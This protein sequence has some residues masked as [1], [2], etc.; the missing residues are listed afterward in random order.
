ANLRIAARNQ[1]IHPATVAGNRRTRS[2][3]GCRSAFRGRAPHYGRR[4]DFCFSRRR[5]WARMDRR[6]AGAGERS[7]RGGTAGQAAP[8]LRAPGLAA[9]R[10]GE[11]VSRR[12][13]AALGIRLLLAQG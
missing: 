2:P 9:F 12:T 7:T 4:T 3:G 5:R 11:V 6:R 1:A 13:A 8:T 10:P